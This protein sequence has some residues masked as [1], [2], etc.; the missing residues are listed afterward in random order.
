MIRKKRGRRT[1]NLSDVE[2]FLMIVRTQSITKA[3]ELLFLSQPTVSQ[4]LRALEEIL[5]YPLLLRS[6]GLKR[7][8]LTQQG[9]EFLPLAER[10]VTLWKESCHLQ[11]R[12]ERPA[13]DV[14]CADSVNTAL[15]ARLYRR[16]LREGDMDLRLHTH[17]SSELYGI[18]DA[19]DIDLAL[20]FYPLHYKNIICQKVFQEKLYLLQS[21]NPAVAKPLVHTDELDPSWELYLHWNDQ[22]QLWHDQWL[23]NYGRPYAT[24]DTIMLLLEL[25]ADERCWMIAPESVAA[26]LSRYRPLYV[27]RLENAPPDRCCYKITHR[28]A[29]GVRGAALAQFE[30]ALEEY[31]KDLRFDL[32]I[33]QVWQ[34]VLGSSE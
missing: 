27:S 7:I 31:L 5:G 17:Q 23:T 21:Q 3:S 16:L 4:R 6:K 34:E 20:V 12:Q 2:L 25:W 1:L 9:A 13:L 15:L 32:H 8:E 24:A 26:E 29:P 19:R 33:G 14:G 18:L 22:Y 28:Q 11:A 10:M 30:A